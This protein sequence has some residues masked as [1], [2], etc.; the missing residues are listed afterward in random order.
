MGVEPFR[1][2][3]SYLKVEM[4]W[5]ERILLNAVAKARALEAKTARHGKT[6]ADRASR[7][8]WV[9]L[10]NFEKVGYD[11]PPPAPNPIAKPAQSYQQQLEARIRQSQAVG[12]Q[13][14]L[15]ALCDRYGLSQF[16]RQ[17]L[18]LAIA[19]EV[20]RRYGELCG[21]LTG[22]S[23]GQNSGQNSGQGAIGLPTVD[24]ALRLFCRDDQ[25]WRLGRSQLLSGPLATEGLLVPF[26]LTPQSFLQQP[27]KLN[28]YWVSELLGGAGNHAVGSHGVGELGVKT[29]GI[30]EVSVSPIAP[31]PTAETPL[32]AKLK[33]QVKRSTTRLK[34]VSNRGSGVL[35]V[36]LDR[37]SNDSEDWAGFYGA[38][39]KTM[40]MQP[41]SLDLAVL[42][43]RDLCPI[44]QLL[45]IVS[46][47]P[48]L[49]VIRSAGRLLSRNAPLSSV[50]KNQFIRQMRSDYDL[51]LLETPYPIALEQVWRSWIQE[52][53][54]FPLSAC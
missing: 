52:N 6:A 10:M 18:L 34:T 53:C 14:V 50:E 37:L 40:K 20:H 4:N 7:D 1:D 13:L 29:G 49:L 8:W 9:G 33:T 43:L 48:R 3:W 41:Y 54:L 21:Y 38:I 47:V 36:G 11:S 12:V 25:A 32:S 30:G 31:I 5:L 24:L 39:A 45:P 2:N 16:E 42:N 46:D 44:A 51:V 22:Q 15:P 26:L 28:P 35:S 19:P 23:I 27:L 17:A